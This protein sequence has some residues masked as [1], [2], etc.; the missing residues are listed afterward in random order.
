MGLKL[1]TLPTVEP[2]SLEE[3]KAHLRVDGADEN[4]LIGALVTAARRFLESFTLRALITQTWVLTLDSA[5][6]E[7]EIPRPPL[8]KVNSIKVVLEDGTESEID[9]SLYWVDT[10]GGGPGRLRLKTGVSWPEHRGF[11]S[12]II[13]FDAGYGD[14]AADVPEDLRRALLQA[15]G[16]LYENRESQEMPEGARIL[17]WPYRII[18]L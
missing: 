16:H 15:V 13:D 11:A 9:P 17:A 4:A 3:A 18:R 7:V 2:A 14:A 10:S 6:D 12:I 8:Q 1:K 5:G